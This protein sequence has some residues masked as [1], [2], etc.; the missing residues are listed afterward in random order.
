MHELLVFDPAMCC[1]TGVCDAEV[2][3]EVVRFAAGLAERAA[4]VPMLAEP[5]VG[6]ER[7]RALARGGAHQLENLD[8]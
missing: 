3:T 6:P 2:D 1:S 8:V 4:V 5:P 7:L